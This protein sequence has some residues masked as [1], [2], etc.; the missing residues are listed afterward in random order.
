MV[1]KLY[2]AMYYKGVDE[3]GYKVDV[4][5][6]ADED[7]AREAAAYWELQK[8][9]EVA[10]VVPRFYG[11]WTVE[12]ETPTH[13]VVRPVRL[14]LMEHTIGDSMLDIDPTDLSESLRSYIL[15]QAL[16][17]DAGVIHHDVCP[18]NII[19]MGSDLEMSIDAMKASVKII[20][21]NIAILTNHPHYADRK[22]PSSPEFDAS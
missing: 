3:C 11:A 8:H 14:V 20:D 18:Q 10:A 12:V 19:I 16:L 2:D 9:P 21:F 17:H 13:R 15:K 5:V 6:E 4:V 1:A 22:Y 7:D